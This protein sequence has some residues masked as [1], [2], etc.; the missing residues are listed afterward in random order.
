VKPTSCWIHK[1]MFKTQTLKWIINTWWMINNKFFMDKIRIMCQIIKT[2]SINSKWFPSTPN[3][4]NQLKINR[5]RFTLIRYIINQSNHHMFKVIPNLIRIILQYRISPM[6]QIPYNK[7][8]NN[9]KSGYNLLNK[10]SNKKVVSL[11]E[12][13]KLHKRW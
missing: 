9:Q 7:T 12:K 2:T 13:V 8:K 4:C 1:K 6:L 10:W 5:V 11:K 3:L